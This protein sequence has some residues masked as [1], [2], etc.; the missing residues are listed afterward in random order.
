MK[1]KTNNIS[2]K[3]FAIIGL[4]VDLFF[5]ILAFDSGDDLV[6]AII[7]FALFELTFHINLFLTY[8]AFLKDGD[9]FEIFFKETKSK[10]IPFFV[11]V[12]IDEIL[13]AI[14]FAILKNTWYLLGLVIPVTIL[15]LLFAIWQYFNKDSKRL[16]AKATNKYLGVAVNNHFVFDGV[17]VL[18]E[19]VAQKM[20][21]KKMLLF[22]PFNTKY[23]FV[24]D[25]ILYVSGKDYKFYVATH[26]ISELYSLVF[27]AR[28]KDALRCRLNKQT[29]QDY[30]VNKNIYVAYC[31]SGA[32]SAD[33]FVYSGDKLRYKITNKKQDGTQKSFVNIEQKTDLPNL[34]TENKISNWF[35]NTFSFDSRKQ[36]DDFVKFVIEQIKLEEEQKNV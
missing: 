26:K 27:L 36:A 11:F 33:D 5:C 30:E 14:C 19:K 31:L 23:H 17:D 22:N 4:L 15:I 16:R 12:S 20:D 1:E 2:K 13:V 35:G 9:G 25:A 7:F 29:E 21:S 24:A 34:T 32:E 28:N 8:V 18:S 6:F 10:M 3:I